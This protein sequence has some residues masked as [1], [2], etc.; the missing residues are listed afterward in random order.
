MLG[1][2]L[3]NPLAP[4]S[5]AVQIMRMEALESE[6]L[7]HCRDVI[8]RQI[9]QMSRLVDDLLDV[10]RI[11]SGK[12][13]IARNTLDLRGAFADA[14][15]TVEADARRRAQILRVEMPE[16]PAWVSGD[17]E[18]LVQVLG[19]LLN[20]AVKFT[21]PGGVITASLREADGWVEFAVRDNGPGIAP[22]H[23]VDVFNPF[24]QGQQDAARSQGGLGL[25]LSLVQQLVSLHGGEV[26]AS[27]S[28]QPGEGAEFRIRLPRAGEPGAVVT[29]AAPPASTAS[30]HL[31]VV[32]DN[33][34][35]ADSL[36]VLL[37]RVG[38]RCHVAYDGQAALQAVRGTRF[39]AVIIDLGLPD[40]NG[41]EVARV[42]RG[43]LRA[44]PPF[45]AVTGYGQDSDLAATRA[46]GFHAHL[47]KPVAA[48]QI[49][50]TLAVL[51]E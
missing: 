25:G 32:D 47:T 36:R 18:R 12:I 35:A 15:E 41:V 37:Q 44:A 39:D 24:V 45:I 7:R 23:L 26:S 48:E 27:S 9:R 51:F 14:V 11:T 17:H 46:A 22:E 30:R 10:G 31:L 5:N 2:E 29:D 13:R 4:I 20:N 38:Y 3:R 33:H 43:E 50:R 6:T 1:H 19:N 8:A 49:T 34:D 40:F 21:Q 28:G 42:L 16:T